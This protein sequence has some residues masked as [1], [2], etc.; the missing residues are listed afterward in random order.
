V[1]ESE[2]LACTDPQPML[3][4]IRGKVS[5]RKLMLFAVACCRHLWND[6]N[7]KLQGVVEAAE[8]FA[9][10]KV[11]EQR[12]WEVFSKAR[13]RVRSGSTPYN[14]GEYEIKSAVLATLRLGSDVPLE[15]ASRSLLIAAYW[16]GPPGYDRTSIEA[17]YAAREEER[18]RQTATVRC[19]FGH[20]FHGDSID[21]TRLRW[22]DGLLVSMARQMYDSSDFAGMPVLADA[23]EDAGCTNQDILI[24]CRR[25]GE[26]VRGCWVVDL[27]LG[28]S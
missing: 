9:D 12:L 15:T 11:D 19:V 13:Q 7:H 6:I 22:H 14:S 1:T 26:H 2:W 18:A 25:A 24:H 3:E 8:M 21:P 4:F 27:L 16:A 28:K 23:L 20:I 10:G 17:R 5:D